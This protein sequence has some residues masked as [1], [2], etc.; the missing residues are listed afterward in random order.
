MG[1]V[2]GTRGDVCG[3][4]GQLNTGRQGKKVQNCVC[5]PAEVL[6]CWPAS[7]PCF[8]R[9]CPPLSPCNPFQSSFR[10][11]RCPHTWRSWEGG[12]RA[13]GSV[14]SQLPVTRGWRSSAWTCQRPVVLT[15]P[16]PPVSPQVRRCCSQFSMS[17][18]RTPVTCP[19]SGGCAAQAGLRAG[20]RPAGRHLPLC[21][22]GPSLR[23][24][25]VLPVVSG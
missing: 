14:P 23:A 7:L 11:P 16:F 12:G 3:S 10:I 22:R 18:T 13:W 5:L 20:Q 2:S 25:A 1:A 4:G 19:E 8:A 6:R 15:S 21:H 17:R 9:P 24:L